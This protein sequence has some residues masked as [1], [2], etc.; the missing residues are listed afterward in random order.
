MPP[1]SDATHVYWVGGTNIYRIP[2]EG[3]A[4]EM[5][6]GSIPNLVDIEVDG[7]TVFY[8]TD[9]DAA[10]S[11]LG[12]VPTTGG[13]PTV[14]GVMQGA[15]GMA[16]DTTHL[17][18]T[19]RYQGIF[20]L[21]K[22]GGAAEPLDST[23][24]LA[25]GIAVDAT[26]VYWA[27]IHTGATHDEM[28]L[29][30]TPLAGGTGPSLADNLGWPV[31]IAADGQSVFSSWRTSVGGYPHR[32]T[33]VDAAGG[34]PVDLL[35]PEVEPGFLAVDETHLYFTLADGTV[36]RIAKAGGSPELL[37]S[38]QLTLTSLALDDVAVYWT[39]G[40]ESSGTAAVV[41]LAK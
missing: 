23:D 13:T 21:A 18:W 30:K 29:I 32:I 3:G 22:T 10:D 16:L 26:S 6:A 11:D 12:S 15:V 40:P 37:A 17:Y 24:S 2:R 5:I 4:T 38:D 33:R 34:E 36:Q 14:L 25:H 9:A 20:R 27:Y 7:T 39:T 35:N 41:K 19:S 8:G 1:T 28:A 31:D